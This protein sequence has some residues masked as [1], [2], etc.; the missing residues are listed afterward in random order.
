MALILFLHIAITAYCLKQ[1]FKLRDQTG[2]HLGM[3]IAML[4]GGFSG[5][6]TGMVIIDYFPFYFVF[7][8]L[9][10]AVAGGLTGAVTGLFYDGQTAL[11]GLSNGFMMGLMGPMIGAAAGGLTILPVMLEIIYVCLIALALTSV[12]KS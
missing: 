8:T 12:V 5:L 1:F 6:I 2:F 10:A 11:T 3:N 9:V 7:L 4:T